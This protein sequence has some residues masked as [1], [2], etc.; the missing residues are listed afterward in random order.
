VYD[1]ER[2]YFEEVFDSFSRT[3]VDLIEIKTITQ[4]RTIETLLRYKN[5]ALIY[6][7]HIVYGSDHILVLSRLAKP[8]G[9]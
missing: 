9:V 1:V 5:L 6:I 2:T 7:R 8:R 4:Y 3:L